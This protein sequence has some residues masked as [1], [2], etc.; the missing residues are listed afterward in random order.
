MIGPG[1]VLR[2]SGETGV[3]LRCRSDDL[4]IFLRNFSLKESERWGEEGCFGEG[5]P[6]DE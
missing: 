2:A 3:C 4:I 1:D 6:L 5:V